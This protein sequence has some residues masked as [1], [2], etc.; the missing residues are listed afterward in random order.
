VHNAGRRGVKVW[1]RVRVHDVVG[2]S[3]SRTVQLTLRATSRT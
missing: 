2:R 1:A 3:S